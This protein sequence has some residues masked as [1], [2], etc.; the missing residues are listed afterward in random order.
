[1]S[2]PYRSRTTDQ[3]PA[4]AHEMAEHHA[5]GGVVIGHQHAQKRDQHGRFAGAFLGAARYIAGA[6]HH[7]EKPITEDNQMDQLGIRG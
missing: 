5:D 4:W 7:P 6:V 3:N 2:H 1:M